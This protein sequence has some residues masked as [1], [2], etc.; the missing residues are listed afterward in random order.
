MILCANPKEQYFSYK[1]EIDNAIS[2]VLKK[3]MYILGDEVTAF[4]NEFAEFN[5]VLGGVGVSSGTD[6]IHIALKAY[7][8]GSGD[9][10]ITVSHTAVATVA[11]IEL[12]GA[13]AVMVDIEEDYFTIDPQKIEKAIT[14]KTKAIIPVHLYGLP[15]DM[16]SIMVVAGKHNLKVIEDCAQAHG[17][18][19]IGSNV[20]S[21]GDCGCFSLYPTKNLGAIGD[22]GIIISNDKGVLE[23]AKLFRQ[24]GWAKRYISQDKG[25]NS[26]LDELQAAILRVK[27][28]YLDEDNKKRGKIAEQYNRGLIDCSHILLPK[29]REDCCHVYHQYVIRVN[30]RDKLLDHLRGNEI[31]AAIHYP[32]PIHLQPAYNISPK[33]V[34]LP[35]TEKIVHNILSL[36]IYPELGKFEVERVVTS[37]REFY[38]ST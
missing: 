12:T 35:V 3:G 30:D 21:I 9:E 18:K 28:K 25:I 26:R 32:Q 27:L 15:V 16:D 1:E 4:E 38:K 37:I 10:V 14:S 33:K 17:A 13:A 6:A 31:L 11:A 36:P 19:Y 2:S 8:I 23:R 24:Y 29:V 34:Y 22:G 5:G 20:G 7:G